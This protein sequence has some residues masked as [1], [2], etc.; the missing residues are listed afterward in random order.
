MLFH[1]KTAQQLLKY[2]VRRKTEEGWGWGLFLGVACLFV[3]PNFR[4]TQTKNK[5]KKSALEAFA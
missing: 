5:G 1:Y 4:S 2:T 3:F